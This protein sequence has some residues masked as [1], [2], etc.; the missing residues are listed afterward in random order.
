MGYRACR[1][2]A[3]LIA[4]TGLRSRTP[5]GATSATVDGGAG[6]YVS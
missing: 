4:I 3:G 6:R 5:V 1:Q 2:V